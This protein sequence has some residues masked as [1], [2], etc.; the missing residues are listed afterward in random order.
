MIFFIF[1]CCTARS[2]DFWPHCGH[3]PSARTANYSHNNNNNHSA[4]AVRVMS[5]ARG[6]G[7]GGGGL[8]GGVSGLSFVNRE[9]EEDQVLHVYDEVCF[10]PLLVEESMSPDRV[11]S[12]S[13]PNLSGYESNRDL[14]EP[15]GYSVFCGVPPPVGPPRYLRK[16][17]APSLQSVSLNPSPSMQHG[18]DGNGII[19]GRKPPMYERSKSSS[20]LF[21][22]EREM[23]ITRDRYSRSPRRDKAVSLDDPSKM[24]RGRTPLARD[25]VRGRNKNMLRLPVNNQLVVAPV[26]KPRVGRSESVKIR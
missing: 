8:S 10:E 26:A 18:A 1:S 22:D 14:E 6:I 9:Y 2:C 11:I 12:E 17:P 3:R 20:V 16:L 21:L 7:G 5:S 4:S 25:R 19:S 15:Y 23:P 24:P 13:V